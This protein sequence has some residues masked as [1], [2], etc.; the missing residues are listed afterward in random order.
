MVNSETFLPSTE[1]AFKQIFAKYKE[2]LR[3][4]VRFG[5]SFEKAMANMIIKVG[6]KK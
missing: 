1:E 6:G 3:Y 4:M 5:T 2:T